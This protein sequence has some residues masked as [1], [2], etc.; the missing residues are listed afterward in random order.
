MALDFKSATKQVKREIIET[1]SEC[2]NVAKKHDGVIYGQYVRNF[3]VSTYKDIATFPVLDEIIEESET[4]GSFTHVQLYFPTA[5]VQTAFIE[6]MGVRLVHDSTSI[7]GSHNFLVKLGVKV[8]EIICTSKLNN[9]FDVNQLAI[10]GGKWSTLDDAF[11]KEFLFNR[12]KQKTVGLM[13]NYVLGHAN[14]PY[15]ILHIAYEVL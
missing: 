15:A 8:A 9:Y 2:F 7:N 5:T 1:L 3:V 12:I 11:S 4:L 10:I 13:T 6:E 14:Q